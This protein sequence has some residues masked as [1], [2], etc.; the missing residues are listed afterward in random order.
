MTNR[1]SLGRANVA[2]RHPAYAGA[3]ERVLYVEDDAILVVLGKRLLEALGY[4][5]TSCVCARAALALFRERADD[6]DIVLT[7]VRMPHCSGFDLL[8][9]LRALR[10]T[11]PVLVVTGY[12]GD[13]ERALAA[14]VGACEILA[15]PF[16]M[17]ELGRTLAR[18]LSA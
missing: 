9:E 7:D 8:R 1:T 4:R 10:P 5:V 14:A 15:K 6:F 17:A 18:V 2:L 3:G 16:G 11:L 13:D 12:V